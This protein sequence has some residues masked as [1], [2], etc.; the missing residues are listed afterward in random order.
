MLLLLHASIDVSVCYTFIS[1]LEL[2]WWIFVPVDWGCL[3]HRRSSKAFYCSNCP[4]GFARKANLKRHVRYS[5]SQ[6]PRFKCPYCE[7]HSKEASNVYRHIR[8]LHHGTRVF[9]ID[10]VTN[11]KHYAQRNKST[12][13]NNWQTG[14][15]VDFNRI[16]KLYLT[17]TS[18]WWIATSTIVCTRRFIQRRKKCEA[19]INRHCIRSMILTCLCKYRIYSVIC[20]IAYFI[21]CHSFFCNKYNSNKITLS[22]EIYS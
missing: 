4:S 20:F 11:I 1:N 7:M 5:C 19:Y 3:S 12:D 17:L 2:A 16:S 10:V 15:E 8:A 18:F 21:S 14:R 22:Y 9:L 13:E 6:R